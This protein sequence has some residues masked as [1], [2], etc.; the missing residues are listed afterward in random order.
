MQ[1]YQDVVD[2]KHEGGAQA[3]TQWRLF[4]HSSSHGS[5]PPA[6]ATPAL[7]QRIVPKI[8]HAMHWTKL[9]SKVLPKYLFVLDEATVS[10]LFR[11]LPRLQPARRQAAKLST[12]SK[13]AAASSLSN[14]TPAAEADAGSRSRGLESYQHER[15]QFVL[16]LAA[17]CAVITPKLASFGPTGLT[18]VASGLGQLQL[19]ACG[20]LAQ[21]RWSSTSHVSSSLPKPKLHHSLNAQ[22]ASHRHNHKQCLS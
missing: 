1:F 20:Q 19:A 6:A 21:V 11:V 9:H 2:G 7:Q 18:A 16:M 15:Q 8:R 4:S 17:I 12:A 14:N 5:T 3:A 10:V 13:G 22:P